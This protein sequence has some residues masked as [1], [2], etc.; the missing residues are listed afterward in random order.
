MGVAVVNLGSGSS[1]DSASSATEVGDRAETLNGVDSSKVGIAGGAEDP[2]VS[3]TVAGGAPPDTSTADTVTTGS[4]SGITDTTA[5][6]VGTI[7][8]IDG[9][10]S[11]APAYSDPATLRGLPEPTA[12]VSPSFVLGCSLSSDQEI[13]LEITWRGTPAVVVRDTV[14]GVITVLDPQCNTLVTVDN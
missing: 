8:S 4:S 11:S 7:G 1:N 9:G 3:P 14:S 5:G 2:S 13:L 6:S 12:Q 10:G